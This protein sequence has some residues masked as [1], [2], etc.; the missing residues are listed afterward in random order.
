MSQTGYVNGTSTDAVIAPGKFPSGVAAVMVRHQ[1]QFL[2]DVLERIVLD[3]QSEHVDERH[4]VSEHDGVVF[5]ASSLG[6]ERHLWS[7]SLCDR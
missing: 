5:A 1:Q 7:G 2:L 6:D 4:L 3:R